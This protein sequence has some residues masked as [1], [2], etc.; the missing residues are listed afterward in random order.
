MAGL[1]V[2]RRLLVAGD[3]RHRHRAAELGRLAVH[4]RR[5]AA[6]RAARPGRTP[7][8]SHSSGSQRSSRMSNSSVRE[9]FEKSVTCSPVSLKT[10][11][12]SI[13]PKAASA[14]HV[15]LADQPL[16]LRAG[17]VGVEHEPGALAHERL[18]A[19]LAQLVAAARR[20]GGPARRS[21]GAA[22][23]RVSRS[24]ATTVS[25]WLVMPMPVELA[26]VDARRVERLARHRARHVPDLG[27]VVLHPAGPREVLAGTRGR[28][29]RPGGPAR[30]T[31]CRSCPVVPWSIARIKAEAQA[32]GGAR[33]A[34]QV[35]PAAYPAG[36]VPAHARRR[37]PH[38]GNRL[39]D[40]VR[41][42]PVGRGGRHA[43]DP[44]VDEDGDAGRGR[45]RRHGQGDRLRRRASRC[46]R[47]TRSS[48]SSDGEAPARRAGRRSRAAH[49][50]QPR[51]PRRAR[52]RDPRRAR[53]GTRARWT[54]AAS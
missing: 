33:C 35:I 36:I 8:S 38:H 40:R 49:D 16:D 1:A 18:V 51:A 3:A 50:R 32:P 52:P 30:R 28:R 45:G 48:S 14:R 17:E 9:A 15:A 44:R 37:S 27:R 5:S 47:A 6:A 39:E 34:A 24:Q 31:R 26:A 2:E 41:G 25:R 21:R 20:C 23:R 7:S 4:V 43:R 22:A 46:P 53:R 13:V 29:A 42:R 11:Q 19:G 12:E 10:S 54:R